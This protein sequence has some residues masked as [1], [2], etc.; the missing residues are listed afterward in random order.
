MEFI[1]LVQVIFGAHIQNRKFTCRATILEFL[2]FEPV[3]FRIQYTALIGCRTLS[4]A[5]YSVVC[6]SHVWSPYSAKIG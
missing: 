2:H 5:Q 3:M 4:N 6:A 1:V